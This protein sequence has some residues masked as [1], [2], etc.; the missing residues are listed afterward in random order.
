MNDNAKYPALKEAYDNYIKQYRAY[1]AYQKY[2]GLSEEE[3]AN[4]TPVEPATQPEALAL[5]YGH[6]I[7]S[8]TD[9]TQFFCDQVFG[10]G[11][12]MKLVGVLVKETNE[13][14]YVP[15]LLSDLIATVTVYS[16]A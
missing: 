9:R 5:S 14:V 13:T 7:E 6:V 11:T 4:T 10:S 8:D 1:E 15:Q 3:K 2:L 12:P 16:P